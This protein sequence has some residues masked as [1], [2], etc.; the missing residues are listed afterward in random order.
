MRACKIQAHS[1]TATGKN[2]PTQE[3]LLQYSISGDENENENGESIGED[4]I[5]VPPPIINDDAEL[6]GSFD[7]GRMSET[8][9][10][11][12]RASKS[13]VNSKSELNVSV[14]EEVAPVVE[15]LDRE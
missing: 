14:H 13:G 11:R 15:E 7:S 6:E 3:E 5:A 1:H 10:N 2:F 12:N 4:V 8:Q 9:T